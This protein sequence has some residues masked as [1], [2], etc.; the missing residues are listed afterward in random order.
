MFRVSQHPSPGVL[1]TVPAASGTG[2]TTCTVT[3]LQRGLIG[4]LLLITM[5]GTTSLKKIIKLGWFINSRVDTCHSSV[6]C[7]FHASPCLTVRVNL[8]HLSL[9]CRNFRSVTAILCEHKTRLVILCVYMSGR[10][11]V[12][13]QHNECNRYQ[14][15]LEISRQRTFLE[16]YSVNCLSLPPHRCWFLS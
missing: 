11:R 8:C 1:K 13:A 16:A 14:A 15:G 4:T 2:H 3:P 9:S 10:T 12:Y 6:T 5:H 7:H